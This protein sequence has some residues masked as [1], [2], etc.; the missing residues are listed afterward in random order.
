MA[1]DKSFIEFLVD[2]IADVGLVTFKKMFG[3]YALYC[4]GKVDTI[5]PFIWLF[6]R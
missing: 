6:H 3:E 5:I 4:E 1:T 2:Q